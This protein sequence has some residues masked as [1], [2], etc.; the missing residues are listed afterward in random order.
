VNGSDPLSGPVRRA[1][2]ELRAR[3]PDRRIGV[4]VEGVPSAAG[5]D[6]GRV[7]AAVARVD[8]GADATELPLVGAVASAL[9]PADVLRLADDPEVGRITLDE[10]EAVE[11]DGH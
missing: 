8:G 10:P 7:L 2:E 5:P 9:R 1:I 11:L 6:P 4:I 3:E